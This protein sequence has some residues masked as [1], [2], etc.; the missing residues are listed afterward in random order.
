MVVRVSAN[1]ASAGI[2]MRD[3]R[4]PQSREIA[5][6]GEV[7]SDLAR[8]PGS[9]QVVGKADTTLRIPQR[10]AFDEAVDPE[11]GLHRRELLCHLSRLV[12]LAGRDQ[13]DR[14]EAQV[15]RPSRI[16]LPGFPAPANSFLVLARDVQ[17]VAQDAMGEENMEIQRRQL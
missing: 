6:A 14:E 7:V 13:V 2:E 12:E 3:R 15:R 11:S 16:A 1:A 10:V 8:Q 9:A 5:P 4:A 17:G